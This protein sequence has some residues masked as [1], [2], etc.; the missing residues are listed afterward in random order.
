MAEQVGEDPAAFAAQGG[1]DY[2]LLVALPHDFPA[3]LVE[4]F[5]SETGVPITRIGQIEAGEGVEL[6]LA[7]H[8]LTIA[9]YDHFR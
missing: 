5:E 6:S 4:R 8:P 9:G 2:E 7:G 1:E 3:P